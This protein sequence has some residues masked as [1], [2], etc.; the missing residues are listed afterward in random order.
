MQHDTFEESD[1]VGVATAANGCEGGVTVPHGSSEYDRPAGDRISFYTVTKPQGAG[2]S[3]YCK[4]RHGGD[5][6]HFLVFWLTLFC[7]FC[8]GEASGFEAAAAGQAWALGSGI[9]AAAV[10]GKLVRRPGRRLQRAKKAALKGTDDDTPDS[11]LFGN[12]TEWG[13]QARRFVAEDEVGLEAAGRWSAVGM[14]EHHLARK[15]THKLRSAFGTRG[16]RGIVSP[17]SR[18]GRSDSGTHGGAC[19]FAPKR[20]ATT[21]IDPED[22]NR[23]TDAPAMCGDGWAVL[24]LHRQGLDVAYVVA[25]FDCGGF[26]AA[27][28]ARAKAIRACC[29]ALGIP[30]VL[31]A[32]FN[33][34]PEQITASGMLAILGGR[35]VTPADTDHTCTAGEKRMLDYWVAS[36]TAWHFMVNPR[37]VVSPWK[38]HFSI[39]FDWARNA[40][41][42]TGAQHGAVGKV[43]SEANLACTIDKLK[44]ASEE[45]WQA[46]AQQEVEAT[47]QFRG[48]LKKAG[49]PYNPEVAEHRLGEKYA[50]WGARA[51]GT[52]AISSNIEPRGDEMRSSIRTTKVKPL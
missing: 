41:L 31:A 8:C 46:A 2:G 11:V 15:D 19:I 23:G 24:I 22:K 39:A 5:R 9:A 10:W 47:K 25:Y 42:I 48:K 17:A 13:P 12:I 26:G 20:H 36:D 52:L 28:Q 32:D 35:I 49:E 7:C 37:T 4:G 16:Y 21:I 29:L 38:P 34:T 3:G 6:W 27:N 50:A 45:D 33:A 14:V 1:V 44:P 43:L 18:T 40:K 30:W 51:A